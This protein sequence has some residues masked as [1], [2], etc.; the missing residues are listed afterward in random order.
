MLRLAKRLA[1]S[2]RLVLLLLWA[3]ATLLN[4]T[5]AFHIDDTVHLE[6]AQWIQQHPFAPMSG[7]I[8]WDHVSQPLYTS[9]HP[10]LYFYLVAAVG[11]LTGFSEVPLHLFQSLFTLLALVYFYKLL[12][13]F[14]KEYALVGTC[15]LALGPAFLVSQNLMIDIPILSLSIVFVYLLLKEEDAHRVRRYYMAALLLSAGL[16]FKYTLLPL[17]LVLLYAALRERKYNLIPA[18]LVPMAVLAV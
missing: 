12:L 7:S 16:L 9:N 14:H 8:N 11:S 4:L 6:A 15:L 10:P 2:P 17:Y 13:L 3:F 1:A 18:V 5:K